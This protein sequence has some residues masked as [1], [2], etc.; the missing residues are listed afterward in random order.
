MTPGS[1][2][3]ITKRPTVPTITIDPDHRDERSRYQND[4][5]RLLHLTLWSLSRIGRMFGVGN[6][7]QRPRSRRVEETNR[8]TIWS[9]AR[10]T[11]DHNKNGAALITERYVFCCSNSIS[12]FR[13]CQQVWCDG[14]TKPHQPRNNGCRNPC[15]TITCNDPST[16]FC[17]NLRLQVPP[18]YFLV[19]YRAPA[20][21][22]PSVACLRF[23]GGNV[24]E[25]NY[26][27]RRAPRDG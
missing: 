18:H 11:H 12:H 20:T 21:S 13:R 6:W 17:T 5:R 1:S 3:L 10:S 27:Q 16:N 25:L 7:H 22:V 24:S 2:V 15:C 8:I 14:F 26:R 4:S 9:R 23:H 19:S